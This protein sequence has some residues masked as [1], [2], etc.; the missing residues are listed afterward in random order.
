MLQM[1]PMFRFNPIYFVLTAILF[2]TEVCIAMFVRDDFIRPY[3]GDTLVVILIYCFV[4]SFLK[5]PVVATA[6]SVLLFSYLIE[7][8]QYFDLIGILH[9][10]EN[11]IVKCVL[12]NS[13]EWIDF[14]AYT[15]GIIIVIVVEK[16]LSIRRNTLL[17]STQR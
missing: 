8:L 1:R 9:L 14:V 15:A 5:S 4:K 16:S 13:F 17:N 2:V 7:V 12:G 6:V 3:F 10:E 11:S